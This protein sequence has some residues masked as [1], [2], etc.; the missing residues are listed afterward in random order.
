M[1]TKELSRYILKRGRARVIDVSFHTHIAERSKFI[2]R[3][4]AARNLL[5]TALT[6][7]I[8]NYVL[9]CTN[10]LLKV[11]SNYLTKQTALK[12]YIR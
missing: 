2:G 3:Y 12:Q 4:K 9:Y 1:A 10:L 7:N 8:L 11:F 6:L 5:H